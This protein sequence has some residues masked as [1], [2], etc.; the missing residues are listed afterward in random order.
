MPQKRNAS[1]RPTKD[2]AKAW[3]AT[4][5]GPMVDALHVEARRIQSD[6]WSFRH[7]SKDFEFLWPTEKMVAAPFQ[8]NLVQFLRHYPDM[9]SLVRAHDDRVKSLRSACIAAYDVLLQD[10][11]FLRLARVATHGDSDDIRY[12]AEYTINGIRELP[13]NYA[14]HEAWNSSANKF[15]ARREAASLKPK[16]IEV[17]TLGHDLCEAITSLL[18]NLVETQQ[19]LA[20]E[21]GLPPVDPNMIAT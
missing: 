10:T 6:N 9:A 14:T 13:Q 3:L 4:V 1:R 17:K 16:F 15:L 12:F 7:Y 20:D 5:V 11:G 21:Y 18:D 8:P 2:Q 19:R